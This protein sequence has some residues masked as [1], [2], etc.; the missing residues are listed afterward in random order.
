VRIA[1]A[2]GRM[3]FG[4]VGRP[5]EAVVPVHTHLDHALDSAEVAAPRT[6]ARHVGGQSAA[7]IGRGGSLP[8][9]RLHVVEP[10][11]GVTACYR[12]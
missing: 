9:D 7:C 3:G 10:G 12:D 11:E 4:D 6:G 5:L 2:L 1:A 8:E